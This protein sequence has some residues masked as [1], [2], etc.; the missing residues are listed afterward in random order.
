MN[1]RRMTDIIVAAYGKKYQL[2]PRRGPERDWREALRDWLRAL[3]DTPMDIRVRLLLGLAALVL[4][5]ATIYYYNTL[6]AAEHDVMMSRA[7]VDVFM[8]RRND[9]SINLAKALTDYSQY[10]QGVLTEIVKLRAAIGGGDAKAGL[11]EM[12]KAAEKSAG[13]AAPAAKPSA[14]EALAGS[15]LAR[16][17]AVAEQYP[18]LKLSANFQS[19]MAALVEVEKDLAGERVKFN[20]AILAYANYVDKFPSNAFAFVFGFKTAPYFKATPEAQTL[21]PIS[22]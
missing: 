8:Q 15:S 4:A 13:A 20:Q 22:Y 21:T 5:A 19:L 10:E 16:L 7:Q 1:T 14:A 6:I 18:D 17:L 12:L 3:G 9:I 11:E 2:E